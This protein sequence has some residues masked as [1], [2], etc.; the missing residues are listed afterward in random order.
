MAASST[1]A[2]DNELIVAVNSVDQLFNAAPINPFSEKPVDVRGEAGLDYLVRRLQAHRQDW[3]HTRLLVRLPSD[4]L[5]PD[6][7]PRLSEAVHRYCRA[8]I[9][10]NSLAIHL[11]R[12]RTSIGLG[13][14]SAIVIV[15]FVV[16]YLL[17]TYV[18]PEASPVIQ[19]IVVAT[20]SLFAW[21]T[22]WDPLEALIFN[23]I[24]PQRENRILRHVMELELVVKADEMTPDTLEGH[25]PDK[26]GMEASPLASSD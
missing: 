4:Q 8:K 10:D 14:L 25:T 19:G 16:A 24:E 1:D 2:A 22:L 26:R 21:V 7:Q 13:I 5:T 12:S 3:Q 11:T 17:F 20:I 23:P 15:A 9:E 18:F 6:L